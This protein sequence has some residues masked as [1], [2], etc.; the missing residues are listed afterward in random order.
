[1][2]APPVS[3]SALYF[4]VEILRCVGA[5]AKARK[6]SISSMEP[7]TL[8]DAHFETCAATLS[9]QLDLY[10]M[11][12]PRS[13]APAICLQN[14]R[15]VTHRHNLSPVN[16]PEVRRAALDSCVAISRDTARFISRL[17]C[18]QPGTALDHDMMM[19]DWNTKRLGP[20][21]SAL[22]CTHLWRCTLFL[23][24]RGHFG[25]ARRCARVL[26]TI[27]DLRAVNVA[28]GRHAAFFLGTLLDWTQR[29]PGE[30][31]GAD[32]E[33]LAYVSGDLQ[34]DR[35]NA[36]V[37]QQHDADDFS[38]A[39]DLTPIGTAGGAG[40][41]AAAATMGFYDRESPRRSS[42]GRFGEIPAS[43]DRAR[44]LAPAGAAATAPLSTSPAGQ[45]VSPFAMS[46]SSSPSREPQLHQQQ[47]QPQPQ[48]PQP[49]PS[50]SQQQLQLQQQQH[51]ADAD[52]FRG[53]WEQ[54]VKMLDALLHDQDQDPTRARE[55]SPAALLP[56]PL[57]P[58]TTTSTAA[59]ATATAGGPPQ[60]HPRT[61]SSSRISIA[62]I[63]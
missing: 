30:D 18:S 53:G 27:G 59:T 22:F 42:G 15:L 35:A 52:E 39:V 1:M 37:W 26:A 5:A 40:A 7:V 45:R 50:S 49:Q 61:S 14:A 38:V 20:I 48:Q 31:A 10:P 8:S 57:P 63:I 29:R 62:S 36:W 16:A 46:L 60:H 12:D 21:A 9:Q 32:E 43:W 25:E 13:A 24:F 51:G 54:V 11:T 33:M 17:P 44:I 47:Q 23:C 3:Q 2:S 56:P 28:C 19:T 6:L 4:N 55:L 34:C 41:A 58:L